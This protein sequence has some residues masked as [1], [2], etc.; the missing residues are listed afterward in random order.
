[1]Y[2]KIVLNFFIIL[3]LV[4]VQ[5]GFVSAM[6]FFYSGSNLLLVAIIFVQALFDEE[7]AWFWVLGIGMIFDVMS[8]SFFGTHIL[9]YSAAF[10]VVNILQKNYFTNRS[11]YSFFALATMA[12]LS[13]KLALFSTASLYSF[14]SGQSSLDFSQNFF[15]QGELY[16]LMAN[17]GL[18]FIAYVLVNFMTKKLK[19]VFLL[20]R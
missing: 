20:K 11:L 18:V 2:F 7:L 14:F 6:P 15:W 5:F 10:F 12:T 1:M 17:L 13:F 8:F 4:V 3:F 9:A 19:P 16:S